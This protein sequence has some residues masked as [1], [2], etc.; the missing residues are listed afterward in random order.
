MILEPMGIPGI[1]PKHERAWTP[2]EYELLISLHQ[3]MTYKEMTQQI[4]R[5]ATAIKFRAAFLRQQ[6]RLKYKCRPFTPSEDVFIRA[7]R[8]NMTLREVSD[9]L[10]RYKS[11]V[12][13][14][15]ALLGVSYRKLG[16]SHRSKKYPDSDVEL[17]RQL[18]NEYN[19]TFREIGEKFDLSPDTCW[20]LC[21]RRHTAIDAI[22]REYM[23]R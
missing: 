7:N 20:Q 23:P 8:H 11:S 17:I 19:L 14:R 4:G 9:H 2:E 1:C 12:T 10:G 5:S 21:H 13:F 22:A 16:D 18:R 3:S 15:A 6:G